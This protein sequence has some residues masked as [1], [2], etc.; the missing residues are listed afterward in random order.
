MTVTWPIGH[1]RAAR[2]DVPGYR[3]DGKASWSRR[4]P[5]PL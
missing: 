1:A 4:P 5:R 2:S 3:C